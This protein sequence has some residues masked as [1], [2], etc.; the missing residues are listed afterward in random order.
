MLFTSISK[1]KLHSSWFGLPTPFSGTT[2]LI[3]GFKKILWL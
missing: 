1:K 3:N 2:A